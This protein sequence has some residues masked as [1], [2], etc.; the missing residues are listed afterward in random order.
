[1]KKL[2]VLVLLCL[3]PISLFAQGREEKSIE[4]QNG[5]VLKGNVELQQDGTYLVETSS[6]DVFFFS[7]S[8]VKRI[9]NLKAVPENDGKQIPSTGEQVYRRKG[10]LCFTATGIP[11][12]QGD[13]VNYQGWEK[14]KKAQKLRKT[15]NGIM[16]W[17]TI[18]CIAAGII[19]GGLFKETHDGVAFHYNIFLVGIGGMASVVPLVTG[20]IIKSSGNAKLN[21]MAKAYNQNPGY[22]L[23]FGPQQHG[24][25]FALN[26]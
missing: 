15:G 17:G 18:G 1:M 7:P 26:F 23:N 13:F 8:E 16:L 22:V 20:I 9:V 21:K 10:E 3:F 11:L 5:T 14:Y 24:V 2:F 19:A 4:L 25:G 12:T 6:G